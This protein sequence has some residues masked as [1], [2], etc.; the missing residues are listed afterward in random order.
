MKVFVTGATGFLGSHL[1]EELVRRGHEVTCLVRKTSDLKWLTPLKIKL[2][3]GDA[4][5]PGGLAEA[6]AGQEIV[7]HV[8]GVLAAT[9][10]PAYLKVNAQGV[11]NMIA[12]CLEAKAPLKRFILVSSV[13]AMG[14]S[15]RGVPLDETTPCQPRRGYGWSKREGEMRALKYRDRIPLTIIRPPGIY[16]PRD[17]QIL[18]AF[19]VA[20]HG[21]FP[22]IGNPDRRVNLAH[23]A[24][25]VQGTI[26]AGES[27]RGLSETFIIAG[28]ENPTWN[29][30]VGHMG[31]GMGK[32]VRSLSV[33]AWLVDRVADLSVL[34]GRL[35][36]RPAIFD[37]EKAGDFGA[38]QWLYSI[39]K[40]KKVLGYAPR[41]SVS[42][43]FCE[44]VAWYRKA[45]WL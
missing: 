21:F 41:H 40:A 11:E 31:T 19:K 36:G 12:A 28:A 15:F 38:R 30:L 1:T 39:D 23:V 29:E 18:K 3:Y 13:A 43:G 45:G 9:S 27:P 42:E 17:R 6:V 8:A 4:T 34:W 5:E 14:P 20:K 25:V 37:R 22:I 7:Y 26:L 10:E 35:R 2:V 33:P 16:G 32:R 44:T 24:D